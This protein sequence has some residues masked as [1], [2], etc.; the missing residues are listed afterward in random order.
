MNRCCLYRFYDAD[1]LLLYV[2]ITNQDMRRWIAHETR[3][4]WGAVASATVEHYDDRSAALDAER[5][6]IKS[7]RP[8]HNLTHAFYQP[9]RR[10]ARTPMPPSTKV[11]PVVIPGMVNGARV[12]W[13]RE[14]TG[15]YLKD[16]AERVGI[17]KAHL[18]MIETGQRDASSI[19]TARIAQA[20]GV[21]PVDL[22]NPLSGG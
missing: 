6:A 18:S 14:N 1:G 21:A 2:G 3:E 15:S 19:V 12:R 17:S 8:V 13:L 7:E 4:W 20:L 5:T 22:R 9:S 10:R 16:F 11:E